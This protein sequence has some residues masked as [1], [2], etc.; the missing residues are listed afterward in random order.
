MRRLHGLV[1]ELL[2]SPDLQTALERVLY[3][4][5][6]IMGAEV[7]R[8]GLVN[9]TTGQIEIVAS[10]GLE[11]D[12]LDEFLAADMGASLGLRPGFAIG[13]ACSYN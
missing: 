1:A 9:P 12:L 3:S 5:V 13:P 2:V 10:R 8:I 7:G 4:A 11:A 6:E